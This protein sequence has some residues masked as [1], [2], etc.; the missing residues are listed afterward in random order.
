[1][2]SFGWNRFDMRNKNGTATRAAATMHAILAMDNDNKGDHGP[3]NNDDGIADS[4]TGQMG[5]NGV[6][7]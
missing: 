5:K 1:M 3:S 6:L 2:E 7:I 4:Y